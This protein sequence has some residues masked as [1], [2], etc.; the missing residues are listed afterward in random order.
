MV[1]EEPRRLHVAVADVEPDRLRGPPQ[2]CLDG[3]AAPGARDGENPTPGD[4]AVDDIPQTGEDLVQSFGCAPLGQCT[5]RV[6]IR[7][8]AHRAP[9][10]RQRHVGAPGRGFDPLEQGD[11]G[12]APEMIARLGLAERQ[13][14]GHLVDV[15]PLL[16]AQ[17]AMS[18]ALVRADAADRP[19]GHPG[20]PALTCIQ[21]ER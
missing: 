14:E 10:R 8:P 6:R 18:G 20:G 1:E 21:S 13:R 3:E 4:A 12:I 11:R 17:E 15:H 16:H 2:T 7:D 5:D 19:A 9:I